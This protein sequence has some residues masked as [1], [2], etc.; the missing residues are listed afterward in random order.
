LVGKKKKKKVKK[1]LFFKRE[2][3]HSFL[4]TVAWA[5]FFFCRTYNSPRKKS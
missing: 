2:N 3:I 1:S 4:T 5:F